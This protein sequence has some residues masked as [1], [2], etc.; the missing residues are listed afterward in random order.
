MFLKLKSSL[1]SV[2]GFG[3][4]SSGFLTSCSM[5]AGFDASTGRGSA[6]LNKKTDFGI[7]DF[8]KECGLA[9]DKLDDDNAIMI[10]QS[11]TSRP[12]KISGEQTGVT[13]SV[14]TQ[15]KVNISATK[16]R[17][18][19]SVNVSVLN[20]SSKAPT[21]GGFMGMI[22]G[23]FAPGVV[24]SQAN[25]AAEANSGTRIMDALPQKDWLQ[26]VDGGNEQYEG[27]LCA[28]Q[29]AKTM[30][31]QEGKGTVVIQFAPALINA[32]SPLAPI[33]RMRKEMGESRTFNI[34]ASVMGGSAG[35][36]QGTVSG[37]TTVR[38]IDPRLECDGVVKQADIA[39]EIINNFPGG[40][41]KVGLT[42]KQAMY[43]DTKKKKIVGIINEDDK[44]D[45]KLKKALPPVCLISD[46]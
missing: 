24:K 5:D 7:F 33:E 34:Q 3:L 8:T 19:Q 12:I 15:A 30:T 45:P 16:T 27:L 1:V 23:L 37:T 14:E 26:L 21:G 22:V 13:Y 39:Y 9:E 32:V 38:E 10:Q 18:T 35:Y 17:A 4:I 36:A 42:K 40:A 6:N 28:A 29:G 25:D 46:E 44:I 2:I 43:I 31:I 41:H 20:T 11:L